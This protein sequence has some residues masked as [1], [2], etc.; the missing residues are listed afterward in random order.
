M[1]HISIFKEKY[2]RLLFLS[3]ML[4]SVAAFAQPAISESDFR[5]SSH[6]RVFVTGGDRQAIL[7]KIASV[8]WAKDIYDA[9]KADT[10]QVTVR[11]DIK[12][13]ADGD[14]QDWLYSMVENRMPILE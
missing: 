14:G 7:S 8:D 6:P 4:S 2:R 11:M 10:V 13:M 12:N 5:T 1:L 3:V 9:L